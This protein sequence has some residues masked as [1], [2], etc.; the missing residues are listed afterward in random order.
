MVLDP[1][2]MLRRTNPELFSQYALTYKHF[3]QTMPR[4]MVL[5]QMRGNV[6]DASGSR[7]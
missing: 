7:N 2:S 6:C 5:V 4:H 1:R 3:L